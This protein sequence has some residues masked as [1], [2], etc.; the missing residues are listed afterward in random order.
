MDDHGY[1]RCSCGSGIETDSGACEKCHPKVKRPTIEELEDVVADL[2]LQLTRRDGLIDVLT[3][4]IL[5][6]RQKAA[7]RSERADA[8]CDES[9][10]LRQRIARDNVDIDTLC[11]DI[12]A[13]R[14]QLAVHN[15]H[16]RG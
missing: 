15:E 13:L 4:D 9:A 10:R 1:L 14:R 12:A 5:A 3:A 11:D 6:A 8:A 16:S 2:R 7:D